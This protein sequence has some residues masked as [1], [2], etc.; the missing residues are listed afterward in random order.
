[1]LTLDSLLTH[2]SPAFI[3][4][5]RSRLSGCLQQWLTIVSFCFAGSCS[6]APHPG[7][8]TPV[9][10][11]YP[12]AFNPAKA[13]L[14]LEEKGLKVISQLRMLFMNGVLPLQMLV[15]RFCL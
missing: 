6:D 15:I 3:I 13:R 4:P 9:F 11:N 1:M 5:S 7:D 14:A 8:G 2:D 12:L 10:Y